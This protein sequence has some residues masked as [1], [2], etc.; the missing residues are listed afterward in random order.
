MKMISKFH[1][2]RLLK[3]SGKFRV[4]EGYCFFPFMNHPR[5]WHTCRP[6]N[7]RYARMPLR[8]LC[9]LLYLTLSALYAR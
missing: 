2:L 3:K 5:R 9:L 6:I 1:I 7:I 4:S 8:N